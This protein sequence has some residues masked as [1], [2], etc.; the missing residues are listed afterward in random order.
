MSVHDAAALAGRKGASNL[1][2][3]LAKVGEEID[4]S[5]GKD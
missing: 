1:K 5:E 4:K 3:A 2:K